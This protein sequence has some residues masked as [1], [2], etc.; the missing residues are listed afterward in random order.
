MAFDPQWKQ[1]AIVSANLK[2]S[3]VPVHANWGMCEIN[4]SAGAPNYGIIHSYEQGAILLDNDSLV[5]TDPAKYFS[6]AQPGLY[7]ICGRLDF[8]VGTGHVAIRLNADIT[9]KDQGIWDSGIDVYYKPTTYGQVYLPSIYI[10]VS[11]TYI[12]ETDAELHRIVLHWQNLTGGAATLTN[13]SRIQYRYH[14]PL[15]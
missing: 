12:N 13:T 6:C 7:E 11:K 5:A 1:Q 15:E 2:T 14:G 3:S 10:P 9:D 8:N 4:T